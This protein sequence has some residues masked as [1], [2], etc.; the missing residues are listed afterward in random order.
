MTR[1][2]ETSPRC[3]SPRY[4]SDWGLKS[5]RIANG[6]YDHRVLK[7]P[8]IATGVMNVGLQ[9]RLALCVQTCMYAE[10]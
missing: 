3:K 1:A 8:P 2:S 7:P 10:L 6:R 4:D 5:T 9:A